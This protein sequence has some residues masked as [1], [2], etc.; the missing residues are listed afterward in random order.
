MDVWVSE[1]VGE[2]WTVPVSAGINLNS[3]RTDCPRWISD[4][5]NTLILSTTR[6]GGQGSADLWYSENN[7]GD[8]GPLVNMGSVINSAFEEWGPGF[9][10]NNG[11]IGGT[12]YFGSSRT[13]GHGGRD[14]WRSAYSTTA[15]SEASP[16]RRMMLRIY[17][18]P[19]VTSTT[20]SYTLAE[21]VTVSLR[22]YDPEGRLVRT[23]HDR[24]QHPGNHRVSW[25][26]TSEGGAA[27]PGGVYFCRLQLGTEEMTH[28]V[29]ITRE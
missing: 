27:L 15:V 9:A 13:G 24:R 3:P 29:V 12:I 5:G 23:L 16:A 2:E 10:D 4:D 1:K 19:F 22:L 26:G 25:D 17:P 6:L 7:A 21:A 8:W 18:N 28:K 11:A 14:I 20:I